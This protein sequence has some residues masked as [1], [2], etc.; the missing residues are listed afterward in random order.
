MK[1]NNVLD[2]HGERHAEVDRM[3]ENFVLLNKP[4]LSIITGNSEN[5]RNRV[6]EICEK[7]KIEY[8]PWTSGEIKILKW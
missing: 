7:H 5:M 8:E 4:P 6:K 3:I 2:L 1:K